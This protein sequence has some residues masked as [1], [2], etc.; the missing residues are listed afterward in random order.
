MRTDR[1]RVQQVLVELVNTAEADQLRGLDDLTR[2]TQ[3]WIVTEAAP[4]T[5][6]DV[7]QLRRF[8]AR[9][10]SLFAAEDQ[11]GRID[12]INDVLARADIRPRLAEHDGLG[13]HIHWFPRHASVA[14]HLI[15]DCAMELALMVQEGEDD[16]LKTCAAPNCMSVFI[17]RSKNRSRLYCDSQ[18]CGN[19]LH[20]AA[21][22]ARQA[23]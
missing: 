15:A 4:P 6:A 9:L 21:Y 2:L 3:R 19:R 12:V 11:S 8:R 14:D 23:T 13:L 5:E 10:R 18:A 17:D 22:R 20:A 1:A 7:V 16:R